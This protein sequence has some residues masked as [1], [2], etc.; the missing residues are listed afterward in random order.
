MEGRCRLAGGFVDCTF[1]NRETL[2]ALQMLSDV[3][4]GDNQAP[5]KRKLLKEGLAKD[6]RL[7][8]RSGTQQ[9]WVSLEARDIREDRVDAVS[10]ILQEEL[11]Q[12]I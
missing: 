10:A 11:G 12:G 3:F 4:C 1:R 9:A 2:A 6:V 5:L 8:L 7:D